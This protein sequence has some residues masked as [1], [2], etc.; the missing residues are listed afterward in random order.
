M[1]VNKTSTSSPLRFREHHRWSRKKIK[2]PEDRDLRSKM[3]SNGHGIDTIL[4]NSL[5]IQQSAQD[6][7]MIVHVNISSWVKEGPTNH[8]PLSLASY[9]I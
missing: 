1:A 3:S 8:L 6:L 4:M 9:G 2:K 7:T 5:Q